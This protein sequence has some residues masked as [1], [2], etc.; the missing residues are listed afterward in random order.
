MISTNIIQL[1][2]KGVSP[3]TY[4]DAVAHKTYTS[5][6]GGDRVV[7][8]YL[9]K[10]IREEISDYLYR[11][12]LSYSFERTEWATRYITR[13]L[14]NKKYPIYREFDDRY[15][16]LEKLSISKLSNGKNW[17]SLLKELTIE[18]MLGGVSYIFLDLGSIYNII[19]DQKSATQFNASVLKYNQVSDIIV[20]RLGYVTQ[21]KIVYQNNGNEYLLAYYQ[22]AEN[23]NVYELYRS[24]K[25]SALELV[26]TNINQIGI[27][28]IIPLVFIGTI[29]NPESISSPI[30]KI[31]KIDID[32]MNLYSDSRHAFSLHNYPWI[33]LPSPEGGIDGVKVGLSSSTNDKT[34]MTKIPL[35][36]AQG[37]L[38]DSNVGEPKI[39]EPQNIH[40]EQTTKLIDYLEAEI[41]N[42]LG[43]SIEN[44]HPLS[45]GVSKMYTFNNTNEAYRWI[46]SNLERIE[47]NTFYIASLLLENNDSNSFND[48]KD[49]V[50]INHPSN[51][52]PIG[53]YQLENISKLIESTI[54]QELD[55]E[56]KLSITKKYIEKTLSECLSDTELSELLDAV[57]LENQK[58]EETINEQIE[59][60]RIIEPTINSSIEDLANIK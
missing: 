38:Y 34:G 4:L 45:S 16:E 14:N 23:Q 48:F 49:L 50:V 47:Y 37:F 33:A 5:Y 32:I 29:Q 57:K 3:A 8:E 42:L 54:F 56:T 1:P 35:G 27:A 10:H 31:A 60:N 46:H 51:F 44:D 7:E 26:E 2:E 15:I 21:C 59:H 41:L 6:Y 25:G 19:S 58:S 11:K 53:S 55:I 12:K 22:N 40:I 52:D 20:D 28:P 18:A 13:T 9:E 39:I 17:D 30:Q 24:M 43:V 36:P